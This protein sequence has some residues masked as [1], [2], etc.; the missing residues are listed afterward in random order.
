MGVTVSHT[1]LAPVSLA[2]TIIGF[3]SF[4]F[5]IGTFLNVFWSSL[6]TIWG[7]SSEIEDYLSNLKQGLLEERRHLRRVR[8]RLKSE[9]KE[10]RDSSQG[11][12]RGRSRSG[13]GGG[14]SGTR[15]RRNSGAGKHVHMNFDRDIQSQNSRG[16]SASLRAM[17]LAIRDMI[18]SF[19]R[20]EH[21]FLKDEYQNMS[22]GTWST[23]DPVNGKT[24]MN[25]A[26]EEY[27]IDSHMQQSNRQGGEYKICGWKE[28]WLWLR[29]KDG[30]V[31]LS[32]GLSRIET[33]RTAHEVDE[34]WMMM[35]DVGR[36]MER[37]VSAIEGL[38]DRL[39]RVVGVRRVD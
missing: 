30:V 28:R 2:S 17:R 34:V 39:R 27:Y 26:D 21:P 10:A 19:R 31:S 36:D 13:G 18:R 1:T 38:E 25:E 32:E 37:V 33:R 14:R 24:Y 8:R 3:I 11:H 9:R 7:A 35:N 4:A 22:S 15:A 6:Q 16:E 12:G 29:R 20:L 5:T 23:T